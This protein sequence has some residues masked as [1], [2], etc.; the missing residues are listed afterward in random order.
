MIAYY[1][2]TAK[3]MTKRRSSSTRKP[4]R[5]ITT[6]TFLVMKLTAVLLV[7]T[8]LQVSAKTIGQTISI[9]QRN[10]SLEKVFKEIN[11]KTGYQFF[12]QDELLKQARKFSIDVKNMPVEQVLEI[13]FRDQPLHFT[14]KENTITVKRKE[15]VRTD[16][17]PPLPPIVV[18][19]KIRDKNGVSLMGVSVSIVGAKGG[20]TTDEMGSFTISVPENGELSFS[21]VGFKPETVRITKENA[22]LTIVL[23]PEILSLSDV[24][25]VGYGTQKKISV[26]GAVTSIGTAELRQSPTTNLSNALAGRLPGLLVNQFSGGEPGVDQSEIFIRGM[27]TYNGGNSQKPLVMVDGIERDFQYLNPEEVETFTILKDASAT[28]VYG[29]RGA[30]G[31]IVVT[32]RRGKIMDKANVTFKAATAVSSPVKFPDYLGSAD[33]AMLYNEAR[34]NDNPS[35]PGILFTDTQIDNYRKAVGDN[36][37]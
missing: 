33:Y 1:L 16:N 19:G 7:A 9:T 30:N 27:A 25:V 11:R 21:F 4:A 5:L 20:V 37:D 13:C 34:K 17:T 23:T 29:V 8:F 36:S 6:K 31:V 26:V 35:N 32:T 2:L 14:I 12:Y 10:T 15:E 24:V 28:A 3:S 18:K 22:N